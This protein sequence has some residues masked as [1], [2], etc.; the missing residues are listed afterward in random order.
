MGSRVFFIVQA[1]MLTGGVIEAQVVA[2]LRSQSRA[3]GAPR[4][5]V[6]FLEPARVAFSAAARR[7]LRLYRSLWPD[8]DLRIVP[9]VGRLGRDGPARFLT[10][11]LIKQRLTRGKLVFHCRGAEA[12]WTA[13]LTRQALGRGTVVFDV[14]G[15]SPFETIHRLGCPWVAELTASA[16]RGYEIAVGLDARAARVAD[17]I[18]VV[19]P[20][21]KD[22]VVD[23]FGRVESDVDVVPSCVDAVAFESGARGRLR[24]EWGVSDTAPIVAYAGR[25]G[26][27]RQPALMFRLFRAMLDLRPD[28][29]LLLFLYRNDIEDLNAALAAA[30]VPKDAVIVEQ[31]ARDEVVARLS[32]AD[33]GLLF[34]EPADRYR[35]W[36]PI[37]FPEYLSAGL[38]VIVNSLVGSLP[39]LVRARRV[40]W[41]ID[42]PWDQAG[43]ERCARD[44]VSALES[45]REDLRARA[46]DACTDLYLWRNYVPTIHQAYG[47]TSAPERLTPV[48]AGRPL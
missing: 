40:G 5:T 17:R 39:A 10:V 16:R 23:T 42:E 29:R 7:T 27:E 2:S 6:L 34:C 45:E 21:L 31:A 18:F 15:H 41:V 35:T 36:F 1:E 48:E 47:L 46:I 14:R 12:T 44:V 33:C 22:Y 3:A 26:V 11:Y 13:H 38:G 8:G 19:S 9:Y 25:L 30:S 43:I 4:V 20:G 32:G 24:A 28:A 37:K